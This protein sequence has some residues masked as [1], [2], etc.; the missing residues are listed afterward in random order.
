MP[1]KIGYARV[2][3]SSQKLDLQIDALKKH[4]CV[5]IYSD[6]GFSGSNRKRPQLDKALNALSA[7]DSVVVWKID[8]ISR[9]IRDLFD[10]TDDINGRGCSF[11]SLT[12]NIDTNTAMGEFFFHLLA[13]LSQLERSIISERTKAGLEAARRRGVRLGRPRLH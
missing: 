1:R 12:D 8:R 3:T 9:S 6:H 13:A 4:G 7:G 2:S 11:E 10:I 5:E